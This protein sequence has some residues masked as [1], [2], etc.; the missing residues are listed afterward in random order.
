MNTGAYLVMPFYYR[1]SPLPD[2]QV[3][4]DLPYR[5]DS[6]AG[7]GKH[8]LD[9]FLPSAETP[10]PWPVFLFVHGGG[11]R[12]GDRALRMGG[13]D[14]YSNI[15]RFLASHGVGSAVISY[16]LQP[17]VGWQAQVEDVARA[18]TW[19][20][21][22][23]QEL[24][25]DPSRLFLAGHSAGAQLAA[26]AALN[27]SPLA[28]F[29]LPAGSVCGL[30][31]VSGAGFD[32]EDATTYELGASRDYYEQ[33]FHNEDSEEAWAR[34]ASPVA[35]LG[36]H[37]PA[38]LILYAD[39]DWPSLRRQSQLLESALTERG[40][41]VELQVIEGEDHYT[42]VTT[43][44]RGDRPAARALLSFIARAACDD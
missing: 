44:S 14:V 37:L 4:R 22:H 32:L 28:A 5:L 6:A 18:V 8:R 39:G 13:A 12:H 27:P 30:I 1:E 16:R 15:G 11:W 34:E 21:A 25:G 40:A 29:G 38:T 36:E 10:R 2:A 33:R 3:Q 20:L 41:D 7:P 43:L 19:F 26:W 24:G 9:L 23:V 31:P 42:I 35:N 17:G